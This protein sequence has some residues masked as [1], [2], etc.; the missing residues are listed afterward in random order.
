MLSRVFRAP[1]NHPVNPVLRTR[2]IKTKTR[3]LEQPADEFGSAE[4]RRK[5]HHPSIQH[6][7]PKMKTSFDVNIFDHL[8]NGAGPF[9][10]LLKQAGA[11]KS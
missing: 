4:E 5:Q 2:D 9:V 11:T 3:V 10:L 8:S 1:E 7:P 6:F